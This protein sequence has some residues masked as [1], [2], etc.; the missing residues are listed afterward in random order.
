M[1]TPNN[2]QPLNAGTF[3]NSIV[4]RLEE[5][6]TRQRVRLMEGQG[7]TIRERQQIFSSHR[8][9]LHPCHSLRIF[10][11]TNMQRA[12]LDKTIREM[13][14]GHATG[15]DKAYYKPQDDEILAEYLKA[16]DLLTI[17]NEHRLKKQLDYYKQREDKISEIAARLD[18][19]ERKWKI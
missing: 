1:S 2:K 7:L 14:V 9:D 15:L 12:K 19:I 10:A 17:S 5:M 13:L 11:V 3:T 8:N 16:V 6:G 4:M 18:S